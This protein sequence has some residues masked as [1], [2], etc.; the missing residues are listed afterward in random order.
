MSFKLANETS[1]RRGVKVG[2]LI[3]STKIHHTL[4]EGQQ[5]II[6]ANISV[7]LKAQQQQQ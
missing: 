7:A 2:N 6:H 3:T 1:T 4:N 5:N